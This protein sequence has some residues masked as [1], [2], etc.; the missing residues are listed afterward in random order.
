MIDAHLFHWSKNIG[1]ADI[2]DLGRIGNI[3]NVVGKNRTIQFHF[4]NN[5]YKDEDIEFIIFT[6]NCGK[7]KLFISN[8]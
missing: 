6:S 5:Q 1:Y 8:D 4:L 3:I 7:Y 2:S